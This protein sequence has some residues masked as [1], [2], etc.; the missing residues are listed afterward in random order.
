MNPMVIEGY[1]M[2]VAYFNTVVIGSG[3]AGYN[4]VNRLYDNGQKNIAHCHKVC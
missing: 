4:A 2:D 3:A 1:E